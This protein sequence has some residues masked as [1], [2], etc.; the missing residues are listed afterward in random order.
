MDYL[1]HLK[2]DSSQP[3]LT[4]G[5]PE[6]A[7]AISRFKDYFSDVDKSSVVEKTAKVYAD[8][9]FFNDT[10]KTIRGLEPLQ[11]YLEETAR[12]VSEFKVEMAD[13]ISSN[14]DYFFRWVMTVRMKKL[15]NQPVKTIGIT[16]VRFNREGRVTL[17]QDYWDSAAGLWEHVP[18]IGSGIRWIKSRL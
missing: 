12:N 18:V 10:L 1:N 2:S 16:H 8:D 11:H 4:P 5:S 17:H 15:G 3:T 6:E 9:L 7:A 13:P 14:G